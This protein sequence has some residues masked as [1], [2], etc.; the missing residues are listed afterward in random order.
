MDHILLIDTSGAT[1]TIGL[2]RDGQYLTGM[3]H[4]EQ[5]SQAAAINPLIEQLCAK[6]DIKLA[7][8]SA[9]AVCS[10]PG[11]YTGLRIGMAAAKGLAFALNKP[12]IVHHKLELLAQQEIQVNDAFWQYGVVLT[13]RP[14]EFF[15]AAYDAEMNIL[16]GPLHGAT[17]DIKRLI[18]SLSVTSHCL[19]GDE[20]AGRTFGESVIPHAVIDPAK[21]AL[22]AAISFANQDFT[23]VAAA[24]PFYM[25]EVYIHPR[26]DA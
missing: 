24:E 4:A 23:D 8:L 21:W 16:Q 12:L 2:V 10:G 6:A 1:C 13:A 20:E 17:E 26:K 18:D 3:E 19:L 15:Y 11:S 9:I 7:D 14:G 5:K 25:K 22:W